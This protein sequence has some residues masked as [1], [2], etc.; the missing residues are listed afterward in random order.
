MEPGSVD[1]LL[2]RYLGLLDEYTK[3]R[4]ELSTLQAGVFQ[5]I[6]RANFSAERG[7]RYGQDFY[8]DRMQA[9][10]RVQIAMNQGDIPEF[11]VT[12][13]NQALDQAP[14]FLE[15]EVEKYATA[16]ESQ[17]RK[18]EEQEEEERPKAKD[19][20]RWFGILTP[21]ALRQ[22]QSQSVKAIEDILP[23]LVSVNAEM[24][25]VEVQVRRAR[26]RRAKAEAAEKPE[27]EP[28]EKPGVAAA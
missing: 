16:E 12:Q 5:S 6:A 26:K 1:S 7:V 25:D 21:M 11:L 28:L 15:P 2:E 19:P 18:E 13:Q 17:E 9:L 10:R 8:D 27:Q 3:L 24:A 22:A 4:C 14:A 20:L 23:R